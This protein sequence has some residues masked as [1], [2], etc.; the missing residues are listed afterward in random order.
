[1][2]FKT[3]YICEK[4]IKE[5]VGKY[6]NFKQESKQ[7]FPHQLTFLADTIYR[8]GVNKKTIY[9]WNII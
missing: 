1:M 3:S 9:I 6:T 2:P 8:R 7:H 4:K 5:E